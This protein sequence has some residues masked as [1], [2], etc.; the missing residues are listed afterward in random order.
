MNA[1]SPD[2]INAIHRKRLEELIKLYKY[3]TE[4]QAVYWAGLLTSMKGFSFYYYR[5]HLLLGDRN[6]FMVEAR[7]KDPTMVSPVPTNWYIA[8]G[9]QSG[10]LEDVLDRRVYLTDGRYTASVIGIDIKYNRI[11]TEDGQV[12]EL[13]TR[14]EPVAQ[15]KKA[16]LL[17]RS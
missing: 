6:P 9:R 3:Q 4:E 10:R 11:L 17:H 14:V 5:T 1:M 13:H 12:Y 15:P 16:A 8:E 7:Q 2:L